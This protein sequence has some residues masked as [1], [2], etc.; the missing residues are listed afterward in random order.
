MALQAP[1]KNLKTQNV[2]KFIEKAEAVATDANMKTQNVYAGFR[3]NLS[4]K[5]LRIVQYFLRIR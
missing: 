1:V 4:D 5:L 3:P 2:T